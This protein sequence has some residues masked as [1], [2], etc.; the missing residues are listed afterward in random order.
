MPPEPHDDG[1]DIEGL[2]R[3]LAA[4]RAR[5][6]AAERLAEAEKQRADDLAR[7]LRLLEAG[8]RPPEPPAPP[9]PPPPAAAPAP[10]P[11]SVQ[12]PTPN[13]G[14]DRPDLPILRRRLRWPWE[15]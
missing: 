12:R 15:K 4:E 11:A 2:R 9:A 14:A 3:A 13:P 7:A 8:G 5:R 6:E 10:A 1:L